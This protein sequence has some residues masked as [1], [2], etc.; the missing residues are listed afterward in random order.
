MNK[1]INVIMGSFLLSN[2]LIYDFQINRGADSSTPSF[3]ES[4]GIID[5]EGNT[6]EGIA[7]GDQ[8]WMAENLKVTKY[9]NNL[10]FVFD[11]CFPWSVFL[12]SCCRYNEYF[13]TTVEG[14]YQ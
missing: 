2:F 8:V 9:N 4:N 14:L 12:W 13:G 7:I 11:R 6:Y 1:I 10:D 3:P 5:I